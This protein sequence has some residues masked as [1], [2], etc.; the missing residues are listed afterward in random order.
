MKEGRNGF[1]H[2]TTQNEL[3]FYCHLEIK[4]GNLAATYRISLLKCNLGFLVTVSLLLV[5]N[6][7]LVQ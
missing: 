3:P 1:K 4:M 5:V 6:I 7:N 2:L